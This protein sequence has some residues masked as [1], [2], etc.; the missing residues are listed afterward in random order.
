MDEVETEDEN[1]TGD[2][3]TESDRE[4]ERYIERGTGDISSNAENKMKQR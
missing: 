1:E 4:R 3:Q 2:K